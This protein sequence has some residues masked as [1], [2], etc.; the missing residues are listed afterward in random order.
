MLTGMS[1]Q[2]SSGWRQSPWRV[3][4]GLRWLAPVALARNLG[5]TAVELRRVERLLADN[6]PQLLG[7]W[8]EYFG[9]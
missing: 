4:L 7:A 5:F 6:E 2:Q 3:I 9:S 8:H 1:N